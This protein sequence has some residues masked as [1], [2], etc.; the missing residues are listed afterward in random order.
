MNQPTM[1][2]VF[3][4]DSFLRVAQ[5]MHGAKPADP[6]PDA[7]PPRIAL[8]QARRDQWELDCSMLADMFEQQTS[9]FDRAAFL[10]NCEEGVNEAY[11]YKGPDV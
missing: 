7:S 1:A 4:K 8:L 2:R 9:A 3:R 6:L 11:N 10:K 5:A